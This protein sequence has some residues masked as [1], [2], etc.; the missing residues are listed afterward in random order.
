MTKDTV[1]KA[2]RVLHSQ[3]AEYIILSEETHLHVIKNVIISQMKD[4]VAVVNTDT[5][6]IVTKDTEKEALD[7]VLDFFGSLQNS[8][9]KLF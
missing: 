5:R 4:F 9:S 8:Q 1:K 6:K 3:I 7:Y 2:N